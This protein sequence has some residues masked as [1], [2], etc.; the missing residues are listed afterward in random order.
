M[1]RAAEREGGYL[2][3]K[4]IRYDGIDGLRAYAAMGIVAM[5]V[6]TNG[7]FSLPN[8][9]HRVIGSMGEFVY[10]FMIISG[11]S[12]CCGYYD[13]MISGNVSIVD[14]YKRRISKIVPFFALLCLIDLISNPSINALYEAFAD[15]TLCFGLLPNP[16]M[17]VVGV[18][19]FLGLVFVFYL[20]F[21]FYCY[22]LENKR[23]AWCS[24][25]IALIFNYL[26]SIYFFND[27]HVVSGFDY[28]S[29]FL[30]CSAYF[31]LGGLIFLYRSR[32]KLFFE[33]R[34]WLAVLISF[35]GCT[36]I[37]VLGMNCMSGLIT[38]FALLLLVFKTPNSPMLFNP[39][40]RFVSSI[41]LEIYLSHMMCFRILER[42]GV[43][44]HLQASWS[45]FLVCF[46]AVLVLAICFSTV[47]KRLISVH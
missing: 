16:T 20:V 9:I 1:T 18:G 43:V 37:L 17:S 45:G 27:N 2:L 14:F 19:W 21:P 15:V 33:N 38:G 31:I 32:L 11:F 28:R 12:M 22:L 5:H 3:S 13:L 44:G 10:L 4:N 30:F 23:R 42:V 40:T 24:F 46:A 47:F 39:F 26:C 25:G 7:G 34:Q 41:S 6:M 29:N 8:P 36:S 35:L